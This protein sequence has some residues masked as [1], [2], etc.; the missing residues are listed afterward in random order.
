MRRIAT[1]FG[2]V[3][4]SP[5]CAAVLAAVCV[6]DWLS[7]PNTHL[8]RSRMSPQGLRQFP[9]HAPTPRLAL[10][11]TPSGLV[12]TGA[13]PEAPLPPSDWD[14]VD[15]FSVFKSVAQRS[16]LWGLTREHEQ[17]LIANPGDLTPAE[18]AS[19]APVLIEGIASL[20]EHD[21]FSR[22]VDLLR[23]GTYVPGMPP[24]W[25]R[26][27][28]RI[29]GNVHNAFSATIFALTA[30]SLP[31]AA[32]GAFRRLRSHRRVERGECPK[33]GYDGR[34]NTGPCPECGEIP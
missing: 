9:A 31:L 10:Y 32:T 8:E 20:P 28:P 18:L 24:R 16:G 34:G 19:I 12:A 6:V 29:R 33:C 15:D 27:T 21:V 26:S 7:L 23:N 11:R 1:M 30:A 2:K 13:Y 22:S 5:L 14:P 4:A 17:F 3:L 25:L